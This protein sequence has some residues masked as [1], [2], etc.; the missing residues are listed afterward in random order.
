MDLKT[1]KTF[2]AIV[3]S[4]SFNRAA[5]ELNYAQSTVTM[6]IQKLESD[7]GVQLLERGKGITLTEAGRLFHEQ[8]LRIVKDMERLQS[9]ITDL[10]SGEAGNVRIGAADPT[11]SY[12][13]PVILKKFLIRFPKM[14]LSVDISGSGALCDR[15]LRGELDVVLCS[16]PELGKELHFEPLFTEAFVLLMPEDH[17]L[18]SAPV[19]T[20]DH[21]RG[22]RLL[23]TAPTCPYRKKLESVLRESAGPPLNTMEIGSMSA[24]KFY[25][26][27]GL[28]IALVPEVTLD[29]VPP[30]T[31]LRRLE[32]KAVDMTCGIICRI[33]DYPLKPAIRSLYDFIRQELAVLPVI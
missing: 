3:Q 31:V 4:G 27:S 8:S 5:E 10:K 25:V 18:A 12:R 29:P 33:G 9:S 30:G 16:A 6:Q 2:Q 26:Q 32:S 1:L 14:E 7:L 28:G 15:L 11:A 23:I 20:A 21:L 19:I 24:L 13:L 17:P 22:H